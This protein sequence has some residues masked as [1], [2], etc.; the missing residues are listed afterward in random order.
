VRK[1]TYDGRL[2]RNTLLDRPP[3]SVWPF[4]DRSIISTLLSPA[5]QAARTSCCQ[6]DPRR[7]IAKLTLP[8]KSLPKAANCLPHFPSSL[9]FPFLLH[10]P[11]QPTCPPPL[12]LPSRPPREVPPIHPPL[13]LSPLC[14]RCYRVSTHAACL[15]GGRRRG[16]LIELLGDRNPFE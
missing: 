5:L 14:C 3:S 2:D 12:P 1:K 16:L 8:L 11:S 15:R 9:P 4:D 13:P 10:V 7:D 6:L